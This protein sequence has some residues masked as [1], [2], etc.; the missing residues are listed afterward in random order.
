[1][2]LFDGGLPVIAF[3]GTNNPGI[4]PSKAS[5]GCI[6]MPNEVVTQLAELVPAGSVVVISE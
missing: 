4:I 1:M 2:E 3:H 5:N 6:R